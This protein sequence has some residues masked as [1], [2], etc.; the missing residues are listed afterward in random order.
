MSELY[1]RVVKLLVGAADQPLTRGASSRHQYV[2]VHPST[3][4]EVQ[5][6]LGKPDEIRVGATPGTWLLGVDVVLDDTQDP[7]IVKLRTDEYY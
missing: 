5:N 1:D 7:T 6:E 3:W 4:A 2:V